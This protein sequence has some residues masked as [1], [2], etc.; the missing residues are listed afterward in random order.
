[1]AQKTVWPMYAIISPE[2]NS[3]GLAFLGGSRPPEPPDLAPPAPIE[4]GAASGRPAQNAGGPP[5]FGNPYWRRRRQVRGV[6]GAGAPQEGQ[7]PRSCLTDLCWWSAGDTAQ[8]R[9]FMAA[10]HLMMMVMMMTRTGLMRYDVKFC[11]RVKE[12]KIWFPPTL[13]Y[14]I[15][16]PDHISRIG[17]P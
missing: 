7:P 8:A 17:R 6:W 5:H 15:G 10:L 2:H 16:I 14:G 11:L 13:N 4:G 1:M 3:G 9:V 12:S